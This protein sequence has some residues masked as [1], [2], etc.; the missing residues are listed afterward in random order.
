MPFRLHPALL[1]ILFA[2]LPLR[3]DVTPDLDLHLPADTVMRYERHVGN[4]RVQARRQGIIHSVPQIFVYFREN[5]PVLYLS[6]Y[7]DSL[8]QAIDDALSIS[9]VVRDMVSART[10]LRE[11]RDADDRRVSTYDLQPAEVTLVDYWKPDCPDCERMRERIVEWI[12][13]RA[14]EDV[15]WIRIEADPDRHETGR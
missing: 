14:R 3:A 5:T 6:D 11:A 15:L 1:L 2:A 10:L 4:A 13:T 12:G 7:T 9:R 8:G